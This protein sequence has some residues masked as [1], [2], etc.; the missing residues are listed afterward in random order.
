MYLKGMHHMIFHTWHNIWCW[1]NVR[2]VAAGLYK[3]LISVYCA[4]YISPW[5]GRL[6]DISLLGGK[7]NSLRE[8]LKQQKKSWCLQNIVNAHN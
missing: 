7:K 2:L 8:M 4:I 3:V 6:F 1:V 5:E